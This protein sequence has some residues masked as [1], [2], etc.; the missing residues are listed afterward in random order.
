MPSR[1][2]DYRER[3][4]DCR[5]RLTPLLAMTKMWSGGRGGSS[6]FRDAFPLVLSLRARQGVAIQSGI[7]C[8]MPGR[9]GSC[10]MVPLD[11][12]VRLTPLLAMTR[13]EVAGVMVRHGLGMPFRLMLSLRARQGVAIQS[14][15][16]CGV[17]SRC[18][19]YPML[20]LDRRVGLKALLAMKKA[21]APTGKG[22]VF[23]R[24][25]KPDRRCGRRL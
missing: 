25:S 20:P 16:L 17:P 4:L 10:P 23:P 6:R 2:E 19:D 1:C 14:G 8:G 9:C 11:C 15:S 21:T 3:P 7:L 12:R 5:V 24:R 13:C 18:G 22:P